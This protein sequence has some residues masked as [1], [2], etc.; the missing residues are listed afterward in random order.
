S[1]AGAGADRSRAA[2]TASSVLRSWATRSGWGP[3]ESRRRTCEMR[4]FS[5]TFPTRRASRPSV[6]ELS[7][8]PQPSASRAVARSAE[9]VRDDGVVADRRVLGD[10]V[11][12]LVEIVG[13]RAVGDRPRDCGEGVVLG[14]KRRMV[15]VRL[16]RHDLVDDRRQTLLLVL[17][18]LL[19]A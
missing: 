5:L 4:S 2:A 7:S 3:I 13:T 17:L 19:V 12:E 8:A 1:G 15:L 18:G 16:A 11:E 10:L 14:R 9:R 6:R